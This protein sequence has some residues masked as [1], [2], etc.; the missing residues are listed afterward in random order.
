[1]RIMSL[2]YRIHMHDRIGQIGHPVE[3]LVICPLS[4]LVGIGYGQATIYGEP[5]LGQEPV[6]GPSLLPNC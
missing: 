2:I 5:N 3:Q 6:T 4:Q 1:M